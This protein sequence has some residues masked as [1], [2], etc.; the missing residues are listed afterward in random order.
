MRDHDKSA[1]ISS[2]HMKQM[3]KS[4][5]KFE[6]MTYTIE[7]DSDN[8]RLA[9]VDLWQPYYF[10]MNADSKGWSDNFDCTDWDE[11]SFSTKSGFKQT[12]PP[13]SWSY[14]SSKPVG[15]EFKLSFG[16]FSPSGQCEHS[17][18][19]IV[20]KTKD[21]TVVTEIDNFTSKE[22]KRKRRTRKRRTR[23]RRTRKRSRKN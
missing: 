13:T 6:P 21:A 23:K 10:W 18:V 11:E 1:Q 4:Q 3:G 9:V 15:Y 14:I 20:S 17:I 8:P 5:S 2:L 19:K 16:P 7:Q 22:R 12:G